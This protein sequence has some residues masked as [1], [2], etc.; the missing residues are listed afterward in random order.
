MN[1][2]IKTSWVKALRSGDYQQGT[3]SLC[4]DNKFCCLGVLTDL[5]QKDHNTNKLEVSAVSDGSLAYGGYSERSYLPEE[6][7]N[8]AELECISPNVMYLGYTHSLTLLNDS[9]LTFIELSN[10]IE[11]SL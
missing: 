8:W 4:I 11:E 9:E 3:Q 1:Q 7:K 6:V 10:L 2:K 5:Y